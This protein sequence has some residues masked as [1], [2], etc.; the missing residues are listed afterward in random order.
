MIPSPFV[1]KKYFVGKYC[2]TRHQILSP[3]PPFPPSLTGLLVSYFIQRIII[4]Y[5]YDLFWH[6]EYSRF[7]QWLLCPFD[8]SPSFFEHIPTFQ[9]N[10][11]FWAHVAPS[12][13]QAWNQPFLQGAPVPFRSWVLRVFSLLLK[14]Y[15]S[16]LLSVERAREHYLSGKPCVH[17]T[18]SNSTTIP[19][20]KFYF[21]LSIFVTPSSHSEKTGFHYAEYIY[22]VDHI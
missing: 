18:T 22:L 3:S 7:D 13:S 14:C 6:T 19:H 2:E 9:N 5:S 21:S 17:L 16:H 15:C 20:R 10:K 11:L 8:M 4:C 1:M 12:L